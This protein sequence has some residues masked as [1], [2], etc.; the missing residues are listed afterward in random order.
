MVV[1]CVFYFEGTSVT[2]FE[3]KVFS[4]IVESGTGVGNMRSSQPFYAARHIISELAIAR[5]AKIICY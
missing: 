4:K 5:R 3:D 1:K 2:K